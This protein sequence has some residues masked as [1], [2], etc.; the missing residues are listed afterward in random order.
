MKDI[1]SQKQKSQHSQ[2]KAAKCYQLCSV[3]LDRDARANCLDPYQNALLIAIWSG[4][5][6]FTS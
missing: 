6:L 5:A 2:A 1:L 3:Y 4:S